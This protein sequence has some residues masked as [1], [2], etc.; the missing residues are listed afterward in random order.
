MKE[1]AILY[2][3]YKIKNDTFLLVPN[4]IVK[5]YS[6]DGTFYYDI[7]KESK[8]ALDCNNIK[9][10]RVLV[11]GIIEEEDL[12]E[13]YKAEDIDFVKDFYFLEESDYVIFVTIKDGEIIKKKVSIK[14]LLEKSQTETYEML[15][16]ES[17]ISLS[18]SKLTE[19]LNIDDIESIKEKLLYYR[20]RVI[21][22]KN[23]SNIISKIVV[24]NGNVSRVETRGK[25]FVNVN[26]PEYKEIPSIINLNEDYKNKAIYDNGEVSVRGLYDYLRERVIGHDKELK[27]ISTKLIRNLKVNE[28][29]KTR[30]ILVPGPTGT[31]KTLTFEVASEYLGIPYTFV[32]TADLVPEGIVGTS[33]QDAFLSLINSCDGDIAKA[34]RAMVVFDEFDKLESTG[35]DIKQS[36]KP[37]FLKLIEGSKIELQQRDGLG[38]TNYTFDTSLLNKAFLGAFSEC[39]IEEKKLG[40]DI[41]KDSSKEFNL[42][43]MY[44]C[45]YYDRE[46]ITRIPIVVPF[47]ELTMEEMRK[48]LFCKSSTLLKEI[49]EL[50]RDFN[51]EI[52]G[53][54]DFAYGLLDR[55]S[56][57]DTSMR[58]LNNIIIN[59]FNDIEFELEDNPNKYRKLVLKKDT[60]NDS[61]KFDLI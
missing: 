20:D 14:A 24:N 58:D 43:K 6:N 22:L 13:Y 23:K 9:E 17:V 59:S 19:L 52:E 8:I 47:Y 1:Y 45:G 38:Y 57:K 25:L 5:G 54:E 27:I 21:R 44:K 18:S 37:I 3:K 12:L 55:L 41:V 11:D 36:V 42:D 35:L 32:N 31:G 15:K 48:T 51:I 49:E 7:N 29:S 46:L 33:V 28:G 53:L 40:F 16:E 26:S 56:N 10:S 30:S 2:D 34:K 60:A 4:D 50:K 61:T 39:F